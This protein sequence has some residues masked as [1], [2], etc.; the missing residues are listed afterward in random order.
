MMINE[1]E[2]DAK[3]F[4]YDG[5]HKIY[6]LEDEADKEM[7]IGCEY[8]IIPIE[9]LEET[10]DKSCELRFIY[11]WKLNKKFVRQFE[12]AKFE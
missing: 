1:Q 2:T 7:A 3:E 10:Y 5:C 11:N 4:A 8:D 12:D 9:H 6:L